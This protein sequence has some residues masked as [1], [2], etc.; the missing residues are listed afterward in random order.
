VLGVFRSRTTPSATI[1]AGFLGAGKTTL[2]NRIL[3]ASDPTTIGVLVNDFGE[4]NIDAELV[5]GV[6]D[7]VIS[8]KNGCVCC[9]VRGDL[10]QAVRKLLR[11]RDPPT[12][13]LVETSGVADP[14]EV[15]RTFLAMQARR[16]LRLDAVVTMVDAER[17]TTLTAASRLLAERQ[18]RLAD[19]IVLNKTDLV[20]EDQSDM[21]ERQLRS[22]VPR[23]RLVRAV[24]ANIP[25]EVL[26]GPEGG[27]SSANI[28]DEGPHT[29][30]DFMQSTLQATD[31]LDTDA[32]NQL[33]EALPSGVLRIKGFVWLQARPR[34][35][36]L[37]QVVG[38]RARLTDAGRWSRRHPRGTRLVVIAER[39]GFDPQALQTKLETCGRRA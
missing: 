34:R 12:R 17:F 32:L 13:I 29:H 28:P 7:D 9:D 30:G 35:R 11:R 33:L 26:L 24:E 6:Q 23:A 4:I 2:L 27:A 22:S 8:L 20:T 36:F 21:I 25:V 16:R 14:G 18:V 37:L 38:R 10:V 1:L 19:I 15:A 3:S 39:E 31:A 5:E